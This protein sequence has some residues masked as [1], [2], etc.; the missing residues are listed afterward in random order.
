MTGGAAEV[1]MPFFSDGAGAVAAYLASLSAALQLGWLFNHGSRETCYSPQRITGFGVYVEQILAY[2]GA[3]GLGCK[4]CKAHMGAR[5]CFVS[6][7]S[8]CIR[9]VQY[10]FL[11]EEM[12]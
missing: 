12:K 9:Y 8:S 11:S 10:F 2:R 5:S 3:S 4:Q 7:T 1:F 6:M